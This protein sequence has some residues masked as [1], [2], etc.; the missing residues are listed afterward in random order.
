MILLNITRHST[1][2]STAEERKGSLE[3]STFV[4]NRDNEVIS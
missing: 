2:S 3:I 4:E 1:D